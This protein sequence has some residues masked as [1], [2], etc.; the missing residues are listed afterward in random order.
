[1]LRKYNTAQGY[2]PA[3]DGPSQAG[4]VLR[5][6]RDLGTELNLAAPLARSPL[7]IAKPTYSTP[8]KNLHAAR[9]ISSELAGL[10]GDELREKQ[11]RL[12][13]LLSTGEM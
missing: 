9:Y 1:M 8:M 11:A 2:T 6:G 10:Q 13:E 4:Q 5:R 12:Q 7:V 3:G